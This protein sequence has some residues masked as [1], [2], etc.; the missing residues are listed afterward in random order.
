MKVGLR[1]K[2]LEKKCKYFT[3]LRLL[4]WHQASLLR[5][6]VCAV[7]QSRLCWHQEEQGSLQEKEDTKTKQEEERKYPVKFSWKR[8]VLQPVGGEN[9]R[10]RQK[11]VRPL[12]PLKGPGTSNALEWL[13]MPSKQTQTEQD[14]PGRC[15]RTVRMV[16]MLIQGLKG[17]YLTKM[18]NV[19]I[20]KKMNVIK[21]NPLCEIYRSLGIYMISKQHY[22]GILVQL[23]GRTYICT[24]STRP[25]SSKTK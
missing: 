24:G 14:K 18:E 4:W 13:S 12:C 11:S 6:I 20:W 17:P 9:R 10:V 16:G 1:I 2:V 7:T 19:G 21:H 3:E 23:N 25:E 15:C 8:V 5:I 22:K